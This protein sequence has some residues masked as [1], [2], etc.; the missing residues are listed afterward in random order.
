MLDRLRELP[1]LIEAVVRLTQRQ[2]VL[3]S[4]N[5]WRRRR[6]PPSGPSSERGLAPD[7]RSD[8]A[9]SAPGPHDSYEYKIPNRAAVLSRITSLQGDEPWPG[10]D[11]LTAERCRVCWPKATRNAPTNFVPT[12]VPKDRASVL[13]VTE[14]ET[15]QRLTRALPIRRDGRPGARAGPSLRRRPTP[16]ALCSRG[17]G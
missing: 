9:H 10:D 8:Q 16:V 12:S 15:R 6:R 4:R 2:A 1:K 11:E 17:A 13:Q 5:D 3:R 7:D 14:R